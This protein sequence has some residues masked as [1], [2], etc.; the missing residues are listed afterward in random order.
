MGNIHGKAKRDLPSLRQWAKRLLALSKN[1]FVNLKYSENDDLGF[2]ILCFLHKQ[3]DH[4]QSIIALI[5]NRD[6]ILVA[7]SMIEGLCQLLWAAREPAVRPLQW[8]AFAYVHDWRL[9]Q[10]KI[11]LGEKVPTKDRAAIERGVKKYG[12]QFLKNKAKEAKKLRKPLPPDP[13]HDN[14][15]CGTSLQQICKSVGGADLYRSLYGPFSDWHHWGVGGLG[16]S[17]KRG[18]DGVIYT[19]LSPADLAS[20]VASGF[21]CLLETIQIADKHF[22]LGIESKISKLR[23]GYV[24]YHQAQTK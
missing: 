13:Y 17:I 21:Q 23:D 4:M 16:E 1:E 19:P 22:S 24:A 15:R 14:W 9:L 2:M 3:T 12:D 7:R 8:R 10:Q 6:T 18:R 11:A 20:A 5:P